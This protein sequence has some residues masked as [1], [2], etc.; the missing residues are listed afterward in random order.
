MI[1][2][3]IPKAHGVKTNFF[4]N[5]VLK[6]SAFIFPLITFPYVSRILGATGNG[7]IAFATSIIQYFSMFAQLGIPTYGIRVCA[8]CRNDYEKFNRT[9]QE[10]L[11]INSITVIIS[12]ISLA[13]AILYV[14]KFQDNNV[15][16]LITSTTILLNAIGMEW[17]FQALEQYSYITVRNIAFKV[18]SIILMFILVHEPKDYIVYGA[19]NVIGTC[20]S[21]FLNAI[22]AH[23]FLSHK[24][25][26][27]YN[28]KQHFKPI[29]NFFLLSVS[30]S[31]YTSMDTIMLGFL[32]TDNQVGY[33]TAA[34]KMKTIVV[35]TVT[36]LGTVLLPR[37]SNFIAEGNISEFKR[38]IRKSFNFILVVSIPVTFYFIVSANNIVEFL[39]GEG[40]LKSVVPMQIISWTIIFIGLNNITGLQI[41]VPT[42]REKITTQSTVA[43]AVLNLIVNASLIPSLGAI[44]AAI[45]TVIAE[46]AV[47]L[48]QVFYLRSEIR[49]FLQGIQY[50]KLIGANIISIGC[51]ILISPYLERFNCFVSLILSA[52]VYFSSYG[53][54]LLAFKED[55]V[56]GYF[57]QIFRKIHK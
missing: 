14:P 51:F 7:K 47:L 40:Y 34:T 2:N 36:A 50:K 24:P 30:V 35:S 3:K 53:L 27:N 15:L 6:M 28:F 17:L 5:A 49:G 39:A 10:L 33:Y 38:L 18:V 55:F 41:L 42:N 12:Y 52:V 19:I 13:V 46:L 44:G 56:F 4:M 29:L 57:I 1:E 20:G 37:M 11:I 26:G 21:N 23:K 22:Y 16:L 32:T 9:V 8:A 25:I 43:G 45:G 54:S 48:Y 31:V